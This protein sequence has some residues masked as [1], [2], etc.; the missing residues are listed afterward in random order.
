[1]DD[2]PLY[3]SRIFKSFVEYLNKYYSDIDI[4]SILK[5]ANIEFYQLDDEGHWFTQEQ[6][7]RFHDILVHTIKDPN[8]ARKAGRFSATSRACSES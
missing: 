5:Y 2:T 6:S 3:N 8:I 4:A 7:D 1:M